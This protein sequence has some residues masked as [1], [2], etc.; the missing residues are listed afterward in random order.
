MKEEQ[1]RLSFLRVKQDIENLRNEIL[2]IKNEVGD[3]KEMLNSLSA[4]QQINSTN[5]ANPTHNPTVPQEIRG[6]KTPNLSISTGNEGV[7]T[8]K[9]T[10][11]PTDILPN[12]N[13]N[14]S[15]ESN[16]QKASDILDSLDHIKKQI[17]LKFKKITSQEMAVFS[18]IYQL[19]E[20]NPEIVTYKQVASIL[21]LSESSIRDYVQKIINK[22]IP[23]KKQ[24]FNNKKV[25][26]YISPDLKKIVT[27]S[28]IL[29]L[30]EL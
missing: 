14:F 11:S 1:I 3:I 22:G 29:K 12:K 4:I 21:K 2:T 9:Q 18:M 15:I 5:L 6:L 23:I 10:D 19:E 27:L 17:R 26:L 30:R 13:N 24:K 20:Q 16:I 8:D 25:I 28:T 7:P